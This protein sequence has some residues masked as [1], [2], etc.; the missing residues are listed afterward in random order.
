MELS[1]GIKDLYQRLAAIQRSQAVDPDVSKIEVDE[2]ASRLAT[3][4]EQ[5]RN[6]I[7]YREDYLLRRFAIQRYL[8]QQLMGGELHSEMGRPLLES[9]IRGKYL[10]NATLPETIIPE[11][12]NILDKYGTLLQRLDN[13][14]YDRTQRRHYQDFLVGIMACEIDLF[15]SPEFKNDA[16]IEAAYLFV[17]DRVKIK[18]E[19]LSIREKNIQLYIALHKDLVISDEH[20]IRFHLFQ[21]YFP[22]WMQADDRLIAFVADKFPSIYLGIKEH[23]NYPDGSKIR[24][25]M[26]KELAIFKILK[27]IVFNPTLELT[28]LLA[29]PE[30]LKLEATKALTALNKRVRRKIRRSSWRAIFYIFLTKMILAVILEYPY[31]L[32]TLHQVNWIPL[33]I[34]VVFPP[35]LMFFV[36]LSVHMPSNANSQ[37]IIETFMG[38]VYNTPETHTLIL[39]SSKKRR[40]AIFLSFLYALYIIL[41]LAVFGLIIYWLRR[42]QFN[43][44][45]GG[46]FIFFVTVVSFFATRIR[47]QAREFSVV[48]KRQSLLGFFLNF[49]S[50]PIVKLGHMLSSNI[51]RINIFIFIFDFVLEAPIKLI[52]TVLENL[53][54]F[55]REKREE[56]YK[57]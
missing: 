28:E 47:Q 35:L 2:I 11:V 21:L 17:K 3:L 39:L 16:L 48:K 19:G 40:S 51:S 6:T 32:I 52:V 38:Y 49:F 8:R 57:E 12:E 9:L 37:A 22:D 36:A 24:A 41:Y 29:D 50:L 56:I 44:M 4:Y 7:D 5:I 18:G 27:D 34:N 13:H 55:V 20:I 30:Q 33:T 14:N 25:A 45:S 26:R 54:G 23:L 15:L 10:P 1:Q 53:F 46:L 42:W 43:I 31:D